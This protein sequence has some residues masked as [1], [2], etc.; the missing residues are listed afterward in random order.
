MPTKITVPLVS[1]NSLKGLPKSLDLSLDK[2]T[3]TVKSLRSRLSELTGDHRSVAGLAYKGSIIAEDSRKLVEVISQSDTGARVIVF[4]QISGQDCPFSFFP[5]SD[6][7]TLTIDARNDDR[8]K[9]GCVGAESI[10]RKIDFNRN[11]LSGALAHHQNSFAIDIPDSVG[12]I[13]DSLGGGAATKPQL[14]SSRVLLH[15]VE[16]DDLVH[17]VALHRF[18]NLEAEVE[19]QS[20][21]HLCVVGGV[22]GNEASGIEGANCVLN[23]LRAGDSWLAKEILRRSSI[24][25][26]PCINLVGQL[27]DARS[28]PQPGTTV[29]VDEQ[30]RVYVGK[31]QHGGMFPPVGWQDPN[32][33]WV[34]NNTLVKSVMERRLFSDDVKRPDLIIFNHDWAVPNGV[35]MARGIKTKEMWEGARDLFSR[36]Y[37]SRTGYGKVYEHLIELPVPAE[38]KWV[39]GEPECLTSCLVEHFDIPNYTIETYCG[40]ADD[41][42]LH[43]EVT[44]F[45]LAR[46]CGLSESDEELRKL[47]LASSALL[48]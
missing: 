47:I 21:P 5:T 12:G 44:L 18:G 2:A 1:L 3:G 6:G 10:Q 23:F 26:V 7:K 38:D 14:S 25:V 31:H 8:T 20:V 9:F 17:K 29:L 4:D 41:Y 45:L 16:S 36:R 30:D 11:I 13:P 42:V 46:H 15:E 35:L 40:A 27:A 37:P 33:G 22:H 24:T 39:N 28:S 48:R 32:R 19:G 34:H 43:F